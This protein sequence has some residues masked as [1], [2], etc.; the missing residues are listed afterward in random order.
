[1][2]RTRQQLGKPTNE[3]KSVRKVVGI[4]QRAKLQ[5]IPAMRSPENAWKSQFF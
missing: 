3:I 2:E 5:A 4:R 1:M